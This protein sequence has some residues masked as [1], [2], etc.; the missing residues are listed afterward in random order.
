MLIPEFSTTQVQPTLTTITTVSDFEKIR[1]Q[2]TD[3]L[4]LTLV[5]A[6]WDSASQHLRQMVS[7]MPSNF[8]QIRFAVVDADQVPDLVE[9]FQIDA[10]PTLVLMHPHKQNAEVI[11]SDLSPESLN[12]LVN[13]QNA[14]YTRMFQTEKQQAFRDIDLLLQSAPVF[15]FIKGTF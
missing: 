2:T 8:T 14:Y 7:E 5:Y 3:K 11:Q 10:V 15:M 13:D 1:Q 6:E 9:K 12:Q 4:F